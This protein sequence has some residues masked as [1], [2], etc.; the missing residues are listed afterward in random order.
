MPLT[1]SFSRRAALEWCG[2]SWTGA[3]LIVLVIAASGVTS[4]CASE[5]VPADPLSREQSGGVHD[6]EPIPFSQKDMRTSFASAED[7]LDVVYLDLGDEIGF[8]IRSPS[9]MLIV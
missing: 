4:G 3:S 7:R 8:I 6:L 2:C 1:A 5:T 9:N